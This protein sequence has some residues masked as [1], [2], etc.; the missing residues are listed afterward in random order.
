MGCFPKKWASFRA[1]LALAEAGETD[2]HKFGAIVA[3]LVH[4]IERNPVARLTRFRLASHFFEM[5]GYGQAPVTA[6]CTAVAHGLVRMFFANPTLVTAQLQ[7]GSVIANQV[8]VEHAA[9]LV[10]ARRRYAGAPGG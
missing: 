8:R 4:F 2:G 10:D 6:P 3:R 5:R 7:S 9:M 1:G